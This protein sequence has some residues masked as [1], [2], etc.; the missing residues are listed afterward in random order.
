MYCSA[1][2]RTGLI[3]TNNQQYNVFK[4]H[5]KKVME[6]RVISNTLGTFLKQGIIVLFSEA[7]LNLFDCR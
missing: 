4:K 6:V 3:L 2:K 1:F 5:K 7:H